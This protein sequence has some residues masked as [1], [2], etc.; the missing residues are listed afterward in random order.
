MAAILFLPTTYQILTALQPEIFL[1]LYVSPL[2]PQRL[3][4]PAL[5]DLRPLILNLLGRYLV[6]CKLG[7]STSAA[8]APQG[9]RSDLVWSQLLKGIFGRI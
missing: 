7:Q 6:Q 9:Q 5:P 8:R 1:K 4:M 3:V 2:L